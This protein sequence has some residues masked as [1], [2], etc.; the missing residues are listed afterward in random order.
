ME[1][2]FA[3]VAEKRSEISPDGLLALVTAVFDV[4]GGGDGAC[5]GCR[6]MRGA[7]NAGAC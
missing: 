2:L 4:L 1:W 7:R 6:C 3:V 5:R